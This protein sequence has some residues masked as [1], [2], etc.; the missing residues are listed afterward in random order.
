[1]MIEKLIDVDR[2]EVVENGVI[3]I[4]TRITFVENGQQEVSKLH[5]H[6]IVPG[7]DYSNEDQKVQAVCSAIHTPE[8]IEAYQLSQQG[9]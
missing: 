9:V 2:V 4:R 8:V 5:R 1:M 7:D 3:Q 6:T